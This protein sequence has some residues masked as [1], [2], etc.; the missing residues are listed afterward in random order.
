MVFIY[1]FLNT[2]VIYFARLSS[3]S[4]FLSDLPDSASEEHPEGQSCC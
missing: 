1:L 4:F 3:L 2:S